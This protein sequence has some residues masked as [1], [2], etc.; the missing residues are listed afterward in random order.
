MSKKNSGQKLFEKIKKEGVS[1]KPGWIFTVKNYLLWTAGVAF[2][3]V[4]GA[5]VSV[6]IYILRYSEWGVYEQLTD[7][8]GQFLLL[9]LPIF[10]LILLAAL[11]WVVFFDI[12]YTKRGYRYPVYMVV[13]S[14]LLAGLA[15]GAIFS[16]LGVG[17]YIDH[18][19]SGSA[20][21]YSEVINPRVGFWCQPEEGR[22][23]GVVVSDSL[24]EKFILYG[25]RQKSW[26]VGMDDIRGRFGPERMGCDRMIIKGE[27]LKV[28]G[29][30]V[31]PDE[32]SAHDILPL[33]PG[34][35]FFER[36]MKEHMPG[37]CPHCMHR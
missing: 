19:L 30:K 22:L 4:E 34:G 7:G 12:R 5:A 25:C 16:S 24:P 20:P 37:G 36:R 33:R 1:P 17:R 10:W 23:A 32:F 8:L 28:I 15:L 27:H 26:T 14:A 11:A 21:Y 2:I 9:V 6:I 18:T 31:S 35:H 13:L 29:E 3:L